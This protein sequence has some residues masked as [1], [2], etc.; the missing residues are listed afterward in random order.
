MASQQ[1]VNSL[2]PAVKQ[3]AIAAAQ[4]AVDQGVRVADQSQTA[5]AGHLT[6]AYTPEQQK[7]DNPVVDY[8]RGR[9][10][11]EPESTR[12]QFHSDG[13]TSIHRPEMELPQ[14][15]SNDLSQSEPSAGQNQLDQAA[16]AQWPDKEVPDS[17][18]L[19]A[20]Y[21]GSA[22]DQ[23]QSIQHQQA[24][25][26][27]EPKQS[28]AEKT[29]QTNL[30]LTREYAGPQTQIEEPQIKEPQIKEPQQ[31]QGREMGQ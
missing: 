5:E 21:G 19:T 10:L 27:T 17:Q 14:V 20:E 23:S 16:Q 4:P 28:E 6:P 25:S 31:E 29:Q 7:P 2:P 9:V 3:E 11:N 30:D 26:L 12:I 22:Y 13:Q 1:S 24:T 8:G 18:R 15:P